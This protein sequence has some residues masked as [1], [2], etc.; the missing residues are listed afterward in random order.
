ME[1]NAIFEVVICQDNLNEMKT[2]RKIIAVIIDKT[3]REY[4]YAF[5]SNYD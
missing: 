1:L 2:K 3:N 4:P 5:T